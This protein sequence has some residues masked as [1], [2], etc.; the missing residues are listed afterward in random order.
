VS[1][2][3]SKT[4]FLWILP[5]LIGIL[6]GAIIG[7]ILSILFPPA[8]PLDKTFY[9]I[10]HTSLG[11]SFGFLCGYLLMLTNLRRIRPLSA[12]LIILFV[13]LFAILFIFFH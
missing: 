11:G 6:G 4:R 8:S 12:L 10:V 13:F 5:L 7:A 3:P 9:I 2:K 1:D